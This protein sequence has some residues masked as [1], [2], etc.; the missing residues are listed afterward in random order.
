MKFHIGIFIDNP[1]ILTEAALGILSFFFF[2]HTINFH[3]FSFSMFD[4]S[5]HRFALFFLFQYLN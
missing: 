1:M 4:L 3:S 5:F 2:S